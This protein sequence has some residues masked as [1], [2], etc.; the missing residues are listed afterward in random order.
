MRRARARRWSSSIT[1]SRRRRS[2]TSSA[3]SSAASVDRT[4]LILDIFAQR[5]QLARGQA[6]GRARAAR[7]SGDA[8]G[9]RLDP[10]RAPER[11][12]R[13]ARPGRDAARDRPAPDRRAGQGAEGAAREARPAAH[14]AA[15]GAH[16]R[17]ACS[18]CRWSATRTRASRRCSTRSRAPSAYAADQLF[19]TLDTTTRRLFLPPS[20]RAIVLSDTVGFIRELPHTLVAAFRATLEETVAGRPAAA[21]RRRLEPDARRARSRQSTRCWRRSARTRRPAA[22]RLEQDR[23]QRRSARGS[24][25]TSMVRSRAIR[26]SA[27]TGAGLDDLRAGCSPRRCSR[28]AYRTRRARAHPNSSRHRPTLMSLNDPQWGRRERPVAA[29]GGNNEG[30]PDLDEIWRN[31]KQRLAAMFGA[32]AAARRRPGGRSGPTSAPARRGCR[33]ARLLHRAVIWLA[34]GFYIVDEGQRGVVLRFGRYLEDHRARPAL[35]LAVPDRERRGRQRQ[36]GAHGRGRLP[37][38]RQ[39]QGAAGV[40]DA[41][42]RREHR[43]HPVRRAVQLEEIPRT[44]SSTTATPTR[45]CCRSPRPRSARSSARARWTSC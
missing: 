1:T 38:Q 18:R 20:A 22:H 23:P 6:A 16:A 43:R 10:P 2:A 45:T 33:A 44:T 30:P 42:R 7:A 29:R 36:P 9:A 15:P 5:A 12:H 37:R 21:R 40:A 11:R 17:R 34:S 27:W 3:R 14:G 28:E 13:H 4:T 41:D 31:F 35:A 8:P 25:A 26:V 39:E 19:A 32:A 24:S